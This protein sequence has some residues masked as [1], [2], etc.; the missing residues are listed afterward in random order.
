MRASQY[1]AALMHSMVKD[2][3]VRED[4]LNF[5]ECIGRLLTEAQYRWLLDYY[6]FQAPVLNMPL[7]LL[8]S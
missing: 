5:Y 1:Q 8:C 3:S 2:Q 4:Y 6:A 7:R